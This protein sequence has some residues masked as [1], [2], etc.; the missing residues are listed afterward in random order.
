MKDTLVEGLPR[1]EGEVHFQTLGVVCVCCKVG[2]G[3]K[4]TTLDKETQVL[5]V[6][7]KSHPR[8][9]CSKRRKGSID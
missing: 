6:G 2:T 3:S 5:A 8:L 9:V 7:V 4:S 1:V